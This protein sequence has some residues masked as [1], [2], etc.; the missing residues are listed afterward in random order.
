LFHGKFSQFLSLFRA[1]VQIA[2]VDEPPHHEDASMDSEDEG[3]DSEPKQMNERAPS[4]SSSSSSVRFQ[5]TNYFALFVSPNIK[6][7]HSHLFAYPIFPLSIGFRN[8]QTFV[9][10]QQLA[11]LITDE[12]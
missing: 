4:S 1:V 7:L 8:T 10:L 9:P 3:S 11:D 6:K 12:S 5:L 2:R